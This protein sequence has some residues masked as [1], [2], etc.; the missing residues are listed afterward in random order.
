MTKRRT[1]PAGLFQRSSR[2]RK[3]AEGQALDSV[4]E[5]FRKAKAELDER[6]DL[7]EAERKVADHEL[8]FEF[9]RRS[10][11]GRSRARSQNSPSKVLM[12]EVQAELDAGR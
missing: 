9:A 3:Q 1:D 4:M 10:K 6:T 7:T 12:R 5:W 8:M 2:A 11:A